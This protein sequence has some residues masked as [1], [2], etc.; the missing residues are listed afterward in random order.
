MSVSFEDSNLF[1]RF[2]S[3]SNLQK[4]KNSKPPHFTNVPNIPFSVAVIPGGY[5][6]CYCILYHKVITNYRNLEYEHTL[7]SGS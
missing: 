2:K 3:I 6:S 7:L 4:M 1:G 5:D